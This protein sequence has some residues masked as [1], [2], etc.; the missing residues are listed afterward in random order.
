MVVFFKKVVAG[1]G[2]ELGGLVRRGNPLCPSA[3]SLQGAK[4]FSFLPGFVAEH[5]SLLVRASSGAAH[6]RPAHPDHGCE[7]LV[8]SGEG[9][10]DAHSESSLNVGT[11]LSVFGKAERVSVL[12]VLFNVMMV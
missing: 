7:C 1:L 9:E 3:F 12:E 4:S 5:G 10:R 6:D 8:E 2:G 11:L